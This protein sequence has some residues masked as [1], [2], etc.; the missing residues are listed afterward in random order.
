V[1]D[2]VLVTGANGFIGNCL[3]AHLLERGVGVVGL[4]RRSVQASPVPMISLNLGYDEIPANLLVNVRCVFH[5]ANVAHT[6]LDAA[7]AGVYY[8]VNVEGT[9]SLLDAAVASG[10]AGFV[11][12]S[13]VKAGD[14]ERLA[15]DYGRSKKAAEDLVLEYGRKHAIHVCVI[16][17]ALVYGADVKGNLESMIR[18][19][20]ARRFPWRW[21]RLPECG[22][23]RS[24]V[25]VN[26]VVQALLLAA[27]HPAAN[28]RV[29]VLE[30]GVP[31][32]PAALQQRISIALDRDL[33]RLV[34]PVAVFFL[35]AQLGEMT[36]VLLQRRVPWN[37]AIYA[38]LFTAARYDS[39]PI[40][41]ELGWHPKDNFYS[42]LPSIV[43]E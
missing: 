42:Q 6:E 12:V 37:R 3:V 35:L 32:T 21:V 9:R 8:Q 10:V 27:E 4:G 22:N 40:K 7:Q 43:H 39:S 2:Q 31:Y 36:Q 13:S 24:M 18:G 29:Y 1:S 19:I 14:G 23:V 38:K 34:V 15:D 5:L 20:A 30:D 11:Y 41:I 33:P 26:D 25:G 17:P 28:G 16:R